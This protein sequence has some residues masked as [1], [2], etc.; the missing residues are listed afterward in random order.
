MIKNKELSDLSWLVDEITYR[1]EKAIS[2]STLSTYSREGFKGLRNLGVSKES[3]SLRYGSLVDTLLTEPENLK[4]K[5]TIID[6]TQPS[7]QVISIL[8]LIL[9]YTNKK[10]GDLKNI[11]KNII[12]HSINEIGYGAENWLDDTKINKIITTGSKY[13]KLLFE[14][15]DK[16]V[17]SKNDL[18]FAEKSVKTLKTH[19]FTKYIFEN[20]PF[21]EC[22]TYF[23]LKFKFTY[24]GISL[25][26]MFDIIYVDYE[27]KIIYPIDFKTTSKDEN[28]F[29]DSFH[30]WRYDIQST[31]YSYILRQICKQDDYFKDFKIEPFKFLVIN[32]Y[33][34]LPLFWKYD[35]SINDE[36]PI[37][38]YDGKLLLP[39]YDLI[40][41]ANRHL[42]ENQYLY[43][44][45]TLNNNGVKII[46][47]N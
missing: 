10:S 17:L 6:Y 31:Q 26:C 25:K 15:N 23:Q 11:D 22:K 42:S 32:K 37:L 3:I 14:N 2:Y 46:K 45:E 20:D 47:I 24:K 16:I 36:Q 40:E 39:W 44:Y 34:N 19:D 41:D 43:D 35:N 13:F 33:N 29:E 28:D 5:F 21:S 38:K 30:K 27:N 1:K 18:L 8:K 9:N 7:D 12:L 4:D